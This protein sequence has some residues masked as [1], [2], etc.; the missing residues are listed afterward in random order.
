MYL[1]CHYWGRDAFVLNLGDS[2]VP[3]IL[4]AFGHDC[5]PRRE[6][7]AN[8]GRTLLVIGSLLNDSDLDRIAGPID[9]WGCGWRGGSV[10]DRNL[11]RLT[12][13]GVR[14]PLTARA[15]GL[16]STLPQSDPGFLMPAILPPPAMRHGL[17]LVLPH[18]LR[19]RTQRPAERR[20]ATG[21]DAILSPWVVRRQ[22]RLTSG[23]LKQATRRLLSAAIRPAGV[24]GSV[25]ALAGARFVLTGSLHGAILCQAYGT[26]WAAYED[27][28][29]DAPAKW[30]DLA[31][32]LDIDI[33]LVRTVGAGEAW[34]D[35][36]GQ[37]A[38]PPEL[39][40]FRAAFPYPQEG[41]R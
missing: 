41:A 38:R 7:A 16:S 27:N 33:A 8:A 30:Q 21:A 20:A 12:F 28:G 31:A 25:R 6:A 11:D 10:S 26:P 2:L 35:R 29:I 40:P 14:G 39:E 5:A 36:T 18:C 1:N 34:W 37:W 9:V 32:L 19:V 23:N 13:H 3:L 22:G 15:L 17:R 24:E 4:R